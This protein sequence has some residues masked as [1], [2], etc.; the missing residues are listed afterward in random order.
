MITALGYRSTDTIS[1]RDILIYIW[2]LDGEVIE[3]EVYPNLTFKAKRAGDHFLTLRVIDD[4]GASNEVTIDFVVSDRGLLE[5][6]VD[7][8]FSVFTMVMLILFLLVMFFSIYRFQRSVR[9]L[10]DPGKKEPL[11]QMEEKEEERSEEGEEGSP[12]VAS[13][14][15]EIEH[16]PMEVL[17][18]MPD[19]EDGSEI[20]DKL[21]NVDIVDPPGLETPTDLPPPPNLDDLDIPDGDPSR[22]DQVMVE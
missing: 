7:N 4:E 20:E 10:P 21:E 22:F 13:P 16:G 6:L 11:D 18:D 3:G 8:I 19:P 17:E 12:E 2:S 14:D 15:T 9:S 5:I 1:D